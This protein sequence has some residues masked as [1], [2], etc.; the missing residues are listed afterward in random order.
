MMPDNTIHIPLTSINLDH[1]NITNQHIA[2]MSSENVVDNE[3]I[4]S[5]SSSKDASDNVPVVSDGAN[6]EDGLGS[7]PNSD[8][9]VGMLHPY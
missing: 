1:H 9:T 8:A 3:Y 5:N 4:P 6:V 7:D 2:N